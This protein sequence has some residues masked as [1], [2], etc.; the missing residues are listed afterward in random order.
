MVRVRKVPKVN[1][2]LMVIPDVLE[3]LGQSDQLDPKENQVMQ[4]LLV[5]PVQLVP[6]EKLVLKVYREKKAILV[7]VDHRD[8]LDLAENRAPAAIKS[9][10]PSAINPIHHRL[11]MNHSDLFGLLDL[12]QVDRRPARHSI[13]QRDLLRNIQDHLIHQINYHPR[14]RATCESCGDKSPNIKLILKK[15]YL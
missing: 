10:R 12:Q 6:L 11:L 15:N 4:V 3:K 14:T 7:S 13:I 2:E 1:L 5:N 8:Q 9:I